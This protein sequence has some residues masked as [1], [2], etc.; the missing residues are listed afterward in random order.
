MS[1][2]GTLVRMGDARAEATVA[3]LLS[4]GASRLHEIDAWI[5]A[6]AAVVPR[7][8]LADAPSRLVA[9]LEAEDGEA[10]ALFRR[11]WDD[12]RDRP[13]RL[14]LAAPT[15]GE[16]PMPLVRALRA[17]DPAV[18]AASREA[19][20]RHRDAAQQTLAARLRPDQRAVLDDVV[21]ALRRARDLAQTVNHLTAEI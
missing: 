1:L 13:A 10:G 21:D 3:T 18:A 5:S 7:A 16:D 6:L 12:V 9:W 4:P 17:A 11:L 14:D 19:A 20:L 8:R 2:E 15:W